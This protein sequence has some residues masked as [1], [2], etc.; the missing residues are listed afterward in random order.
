VV[1]FLLF[2]A[3]LAIRGYFGWKARRAGLCPWFA[4]DSESGQQPRGSRW[5]GLVIPISLL[6]LLVL[7]AVNPGPLSWLSAPLPGW[8]LWLGAALG[9][10]SFPLQIW[11][12]GTLEKQW[13]AA[14]RSG[15]SHVLITQGPY[16]WV[17]HPLYA[18][19]LLFFVGLSLVSA[20]WPFL[21]L[22]FGSIPLLQRAAV[23]EEAVMRQRFPDEYD[24]YAE[25]TG[26]F[27]PR[28]TRRSE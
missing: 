11:T 14:A 8:L 22:A 5:L 15:N 4:D 21:L 27:L 9:A 19:L 20:F 12:H 28:M 10:L 18:A 26:R 24:K 7:Y 23:Q 1:F 17:R 3:F 16:R 13:S 25:Q 6:A 2:A